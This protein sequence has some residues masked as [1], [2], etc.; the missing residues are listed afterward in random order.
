MALIKK[1]YDDKLSPNNPV[2][3]YPVTSTKAVYSPTGERL[4]DLLAHI[5]TDLPYKA[6]PSIEDLPREETNFGYLI[7]ENLYVWVGAGGDTLGGLYKNCGTFKGA[8]GDQGEQGPQGIQGIQGIQGEQGPE[9]PQGPQGEAGIDGIGP[10]GLQGIKGPQGSEGLAGKSAY[11]IWLE[12]G[13]TGSETDFLNSLKGEQGLKGDDGTT[14]PSGVVLTTDLD[15]TTPDEYAADAVALNT[16]NTT[17]VGYDL[18]EAVAPL[19]GHYLDFQSSEATPEIAHLNYYTRVETDALLDRQRQDL[20]AKQLEQ[21]ENI[22]GFETRV[23][24]HIDN[25]KPIN[26]EG[27]V[28]NAPDEEDITSENDLL[29]FKDRS[30]LY[31]KGYIILRRDKSFK[32]QLTQIDTIYEIRYDF[33]LREIHIT[34]ALTSEVQIGEVIYYTPTASISLA[35]NEDIWVPDDCVV[36]NSTRTALLS[37]NSSYHP[38]SSTT[39]YI[40]KTTPAESITYQLNGKVTLP[41][42]CTLKFE[43]G[44]L[45]YGIVTV[46]SAVVFP[47]YNYLEHDDLVLIGIPAAGV[48]KFDGTKPI[49]SNGTAWVDATGTPII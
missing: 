2:Q 39:V 11:E 16:L 47:S 12:Q 46:N 48:T 40:A 37:E 8:K 18:I 43:G 26:I 36:L 45:S 25:Y 31:G 32:S 6:L 28:T 4:D 17:K 22:A 14:L 5:H 41:E 27:D 29:K 24:E 10:A 9:G 13:H 1:I 42:G 23:N 30:P 49:W 7:G 20:D 21:D 3:I 15:K 19:A 34:S 35:A 44:S 33:D 38:E